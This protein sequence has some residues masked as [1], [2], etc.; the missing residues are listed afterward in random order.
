MLAATS[1]KLLFMDIMQS[2]LRKTRQQYN[3][4]PV[5]HCPWQAKLDLSSHVSLG[6]YITPRDHFKSYLSSAT[7]GTCLSVQRYVIIVLPIAA[8]VTVLSSQ[9]GGGLNH[10]LRPQPCRCTPCGTHQHGSLLCCCCLICCHCCHIL[11]YTHQ[12]KSAEAS[13]THCIEEG[14]FS[15]PGRQVLLWRIQGVSA[16]L[17]GWPR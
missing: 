17:S 8:I 15:S 9:S 2:A 12:S 10:I 11:L 7:C 6:S 13:R 3:Q 5:E 16:F 1:D 14:S 4:T